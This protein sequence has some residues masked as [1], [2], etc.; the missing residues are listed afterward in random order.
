MNMNKKNIIMIVI[1]GTFG[2]L[3]L[4]V[5]FLSFTIVS[6]GHRGVI[7]RFGDVQDTILDEGFHMKNPLD[8][9]KDIDVRTKKIEVTADSASKDL[10]SV[11]TTIALNYHVDY[12][13]VN[14]LYQN[15]GVRYE[16]V[17]ITP[18]IKEA[19][20][21]A[22]AGFTAE[23]LI[24]KRSEISFVINGLLSERLGNKWIIVDNISIVNF[25]FSE[26]FNIAVEQKQVA[27][28]NALRAEMDL[29]RIEM[30]AQQKVKMAEAEAEAIRITGAALNSNPNLVDLEAVKKWNGILPE[31]TGG[32]IPFLNINR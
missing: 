13:G 22:T 26:A 19:I 9:V 8:S 15:V 21:Q 24:T 23:E 30:E 2:A 10:Q 18:S 1:L 12:T 11:M 31:Y 14:N 7:V 25:D 29:Q 4:I 3:L 5:A 28:Q 16:D 27:E 20:K 6:A 17:V 32:S